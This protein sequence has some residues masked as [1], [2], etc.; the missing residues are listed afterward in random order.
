MELND[1]QRK[2]VGDWLDRPAFSPHS[3]ADLGAVF[4]VRAAFFDDPRRTGTPQEAF[5]AGMQKLRDLRGTELTHEIYRGAEAALEALT[6]AM[7]TM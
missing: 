2:Y 3:E 4:V 7:E 1:A 6:D 5:S